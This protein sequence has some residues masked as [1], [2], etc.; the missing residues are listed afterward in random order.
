MHP[1]KI[2]QIKKKLKGFSGSV[3]VDEIKNMSEKDLKTFY[4][5]DLK[6]HL[7]QLPSFEQQKDLDLPYRMEWAINHINDGED[8]LDVGC[9]YGLMLYALS[10]KGISCAG[11]DVSEACI[12][13]ATKNVPEVPSVV[14]GIERLPHKDKSYDVCIATEVLE[15]H[16]DPKAFII[17]LIRV[18]KKRILLT[19][20]I[21][22]NMLDPAHLHFFDFYDVVDL[23]DGLD[24]KLEVYRINKF[25]KNGNKNLFAIKFELEK[26]E[27]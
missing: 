9:Q 21:E 4:D 1:E 5:I 8:A 3:S 15:H 2:E 6:R 18:A 27:E 24:G 12:E 19:T 13:E 25:Y 23:F 16:K 17:E 26:K 14:C 11:T 7:K 22:D 10:S 20:P